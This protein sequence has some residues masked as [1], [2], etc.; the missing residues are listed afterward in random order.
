MLHTS[1]FGHSSHHLPELV[2]RFEW[3]KRAFGRMLVAVRGWGRRRRSGCAT[4]RYCAGNRKQQGRQ[5]Q[6]Q[7]FHGLTPKASNEGARRQSRFLRRIALEL[8]SPVQRGGCSP[9]SFRTTCGHA[10]F[11]I[12]R[13]RKKSRLFR[14]GTS[15]TK[16]DPAGTLPAGS[17]TRQSNHSAADFTDLPLPHDGATGWRDRACISRSTSVPVRLMRWPT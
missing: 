1:R 9:T 8:T 4:G 17:A 12:L 16:A 5:C 13:S 14:A 6:Q 2:Q 11:V 15:C 10:R 3:R 7:P